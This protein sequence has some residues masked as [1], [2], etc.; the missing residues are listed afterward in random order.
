MPLLMCVQNHVPI[1]SDPCEALDNLFSCCLTEYPEC[2]SPRTR[3]FKECNTQTTERDRHTRAHC[4]ERSS[5]LAHTQPLPHPTPCPDRSAHN[6]GE[7][8]TPTT[9]S[10]LQLGSQAGTLSTALEDYM[11]SGQKH[12][13]KTKALAE[14]FAAAG[15]V[16]KPTIHGQ[17]VLLLFSTFTVGLSIHYLISPW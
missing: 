16:A 8:T 11:R 14:A 6:C 12:M 1:R 17:H 9:W 15:K 7:T 2:R 3:L 13:Q 5:L 4:T 10:T